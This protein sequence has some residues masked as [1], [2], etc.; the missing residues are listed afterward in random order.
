MCRLEQR[1]ERLRS[2]GAGAN[3]QKIDELKMMIVEVVDFAKSSE[4]V[5]TSDLS[6]S[7]R[8]LHDQTT[9]L[10]KLVKGQ[11]WSS[12]KKML[13]GSDGKSFEIKICYDEFKTDF[14]KFIVEHF[15]N[16][17]KKFEVPKTE[18]HAYLES[19]DAFTLELDRVW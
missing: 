4:M 11:S 5:T 2:I 16:C 19:I 6:N 3:S 10:S 18:K 7:V 14:M 1:L 8:Q 17:V 13:G 15:V 9:K 12:F